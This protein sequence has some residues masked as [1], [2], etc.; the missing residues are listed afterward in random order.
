MTSKVIYRTGL[1]TVATHLKSG[2]EI[3]TDAPTDNEGKGEAFSPTDLMST[4]LA[5]CIMTIMGIAARNHEID[6]DGAEASV[7][8]VMGSDPRRVAKVMIE[9]VMPDK[10]YSAKDKAVLEAAAEACP[11]GRSLHPDLVQDLTLTWS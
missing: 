2:Q 5:S 10:N 8:K 1:R 4:S 6:M 9:I 11:V 7:T 3:I